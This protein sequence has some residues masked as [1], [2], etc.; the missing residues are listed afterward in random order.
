MAR[1]PDPNSGNSQFFIC[2]TEERCRK[3][4][5]R[6]SYFGDVVSGMETI[7]KLKKGLEAKNNGLVDN[8]DRVIRLYLKQD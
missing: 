6:F 2:Y 4:N 8:P 5:G 3:N 1:R 7:D